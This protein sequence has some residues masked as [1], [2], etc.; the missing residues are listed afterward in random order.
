MLEKTRKEKPVIIG[1]HAIVYSKSPEAD[2]QFFRDVLGLPGVDAGD[3]WLIFG[4]PPAELAVHPSD[5]NDLHELYLMCDRVEAFLAE[6]KRRGIACDP[7][8]NLSWGSLAR[9]TLPGGGNLGVYEPRHA[10]PKAMSEV[11]E[12]KRRSA[13]AKRPAPKTA[14][15]TRKKKGRRR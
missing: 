14:P 9:V 4:L 8:Q 7:V 11:K 13:R 6:M 10:R 2:R 12:A 3:G 5:E 1:A 15:R